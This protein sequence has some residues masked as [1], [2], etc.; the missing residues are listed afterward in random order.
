MLRP[1]CLFTLWSGETETY[2]WV[3][4]KRDTAYYCVWI[5]D[6]QGREL[7]EFPALSL[8]WA[9]RLAEANGYARPHEPIPA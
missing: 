3:E 2:G 1:V 6:P 5:F 9:R 4:G 7:A 8:V